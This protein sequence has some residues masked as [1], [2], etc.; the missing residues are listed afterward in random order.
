MVVFD[1]SVRPYHGRALYAVA[2]ASE[3]KGD[4][5][6]RGLQA[7]RALV[8]LA[9]WDEAD[10]KARVPTVVWGWWRQ[11]PPVVLDAVLPAPN[12]HRATGPSRI[13]A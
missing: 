2:T 12:R 7:G 5:L 6:E 9:Q 3:L 1:S 8:R 4:D 11:L 13:A 10:L